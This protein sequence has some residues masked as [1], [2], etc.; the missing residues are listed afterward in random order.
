MYLRFARTALAV[1][2]LILGL[3]Q[4][5]LAGADSHLAGGGTATISQVAFNV[6]ID[7]AGTASGEF[8]CLMAGR[9][10]FVLPAFKLEHIM[11]VHAT[12]TQ[13]RVS[14][15][16]VAFSGP[17]RL[18]MDNGTHLDVHVSVWANSATQEFQLTVVELGTLPKEHML[19]GQFSLH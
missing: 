17:A 16:T 18:I 6:S 4:P 3:G 13:A 14:G 15:S 2:A 8:N 19:T 10:A 12:P 7:A 11:H 9:S 1:V 5:A